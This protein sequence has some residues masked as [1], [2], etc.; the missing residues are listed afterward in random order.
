MNKESSPL[1]EKKCVPCESG[2]EALKGKDLAKLKKQ[3]GKKWKV[4]RS[5]H[6]E[7]EFTFPNFLKALEFTN[8][9]GEIAEKE[10]HHPNIEL[11]W[12]KV[13]I[14]L[15]THSINGLSEN[16]FVLA[17]KCDEALEDK[18]TKS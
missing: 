11:A 2:V 17:A 15:W 9:V 14:T 6:L 18:N 13:K 8:R 3:L 16:D 1:A 10:G 4:K 5:H 12:G 7:K